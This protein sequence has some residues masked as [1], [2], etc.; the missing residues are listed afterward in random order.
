MTISV[1]RGARGDFR[2][3]GGA[4]GYKT[5]ATDDVAIAGAKPDLARG[6]ANHQTQAT[7]IAALTA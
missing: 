6:S 1:G 7:T 4:S 5:E 3:I 2:G